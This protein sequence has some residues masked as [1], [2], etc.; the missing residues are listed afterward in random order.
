MADEEIPQLHR[1]CPS[2]GTAAIPGGVFCGECGDKLS[3]GPVGVYSQQIEITTP[4]VAVPVVRST[5]R[6]DLSNAP[7]TL[8]RR[9]TIFSDL[10]ALVGLGLSR[11]R[12]R[13]RAV[14][15]WRWEL[16]TLICF[17]IALIIRANAR[18]EWGTAGTIT[19]TIVTIFAILCFAPPFIWFFVAIFRFGWRSMETTIHAA[20]PMPSPDEIAYRLQIEWGRPP[21]L[22]E[23]AAVQQLLVNQR[24]QNL[25]NAGMALGALYLLHDAGQRARGR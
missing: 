6:E 17:S 2:C 25:V 1:F 13:R 24:N 10:A 11:N 20:Q 16:I 5:Q 22:Q 8:M 15:F 9:P 14:L 3:K 18:L 12:W 7:S 21:T 4:P 19:D 23:V